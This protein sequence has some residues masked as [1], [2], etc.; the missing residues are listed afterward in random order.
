VKPDKGITGK[1]ERKI[2]GNFAGT[3]MASAAKKCKK[4]L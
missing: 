3:K 4:S 2:I 1:N